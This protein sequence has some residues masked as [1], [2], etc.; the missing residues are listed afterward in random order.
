[1]IE[2]LKIDVANSKPR[3]QVRG[4]KRRLPVQGVVNENTLTTID[5]VA[6]RLGELGPRL[7]DAFSK[8][9]RERAVR[10]NESLRLRP[11]SRHRRRSAHGLA[12]EGRF[13]VSL[14]RRAASLLDDHP[15]FRAWAGPPRRQVRAQP[16]KMKLSASTLATL[17]AII[18][19][20]STL[21]GVGAL[22]ITEAGVASALVTFSESRN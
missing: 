19:A 11:I 8:R 7:S 14:L 3:R 15:G 21:A 16:M 12:R 9:G 6:R 4:A 5:D 1:M 18:F 10:P 2:D 22:A 20:V 13:A 17:S